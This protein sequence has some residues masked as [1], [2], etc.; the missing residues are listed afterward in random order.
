VPK[1]YEIIAEVGQGIVLP[2][3]R[4]YNVMIKIGDFA[5][6]T[7]KPQVAD[8]TFNRWNHRFEKSVYTVNY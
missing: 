2:D 5:L 3:A 6:K 8:K 4:K 1:E 7:E